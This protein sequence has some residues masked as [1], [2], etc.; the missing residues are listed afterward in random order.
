M[1]FRYADDILED[2]DL[3]PIKVWADADS[4]L[5]FRQGGDVMVMSQSQLKQLRLLADRK[6][7]KT[8]P[9]Y[10]TALPSMRQAAAVF[11]TFMLAFVW[12][13]KLPTS[14]K[15]SYYVKPKGQ[16]VS[17]IRTIPPS[18]FYNRTT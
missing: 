4:L 11:M 16:V 6:F 9:A 8:R 7:P 15:V 18:P 12:M 17:F 3:D 1:S 13:N 5:T 14:L 10:L 2:D